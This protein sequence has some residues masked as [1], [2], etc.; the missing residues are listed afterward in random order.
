M[1]EKKA[2]HHGNLRAALIEAGM[3]LL[4]SG[5]P[6]AL[7]IRKLAA[8][9]GVSHAAPAH[10]FPNLKALRTALA[11]DGFKMF[12]QSMEDQ[13]AKVDNDPRRRI[14]AAGRGYLYFAKE[15]A[16]LFN[17][18][19]GGTELETDNQELEEAAERAYGVLQMIAAPIERGEKASPNGNE[20]NELMIWSLIHGLSGLMLTDKSGLIDADHID[21]IFES[22]LP[23][24]RFKT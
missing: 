6:A 11:I 23:P 7:S 16:G 2:H 22:I 24:L 12:T 13:L 1:K 14:L 19:F 21:T 20:S 9:A 8:K 4:Q 3:E 18:I 10:H 5:G 17:L 15:N